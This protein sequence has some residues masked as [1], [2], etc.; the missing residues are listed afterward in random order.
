M[1]RPLS[2]IC[3]NSPRKPRLQ[4][5]GASGITAV[6]IRLL[7]WFTIHGVRGRGGSL[8][9]VKKKSWV[10]PSTA[11]KYFNVGHSTIR[12]WITTGKLRAAKLPTGH[13]RILA[14]DILKALLRQGKPIPQELGDLSAKHVLIVD[15]DRESADIMAATLVAASG[16]KVSV[17]GSAADTNG[18]LNG[19]RPDLVLFNVRNTLSV[20]GN[21]RSGMLIL[22]HG[23][24][25]PGNDEDNSGEAAFSVSNI[26][27]VPVN[28]HLL[29]YHVANVLLG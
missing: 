10:Q 26:L 24:D 12:Q 11:A 1:A 25:E 6:D 17:A 28:E 20:N 23:P 15:G 8:A 13:L 18:F 3:C 5:G 27:S 14:R 9:A 7:M 19:L 22:A 21:A 2:C 4:T 16:C 29:A